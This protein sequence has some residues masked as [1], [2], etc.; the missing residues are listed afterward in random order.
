MRCCRSMKQGH[1]RQLGA[2]RAPT[3]QQPM[4]RY[5]VRTGVAVV[6]RALCHYLGELGLSYTDLGFI[7]HILSYRWTTA[8]PFPAQR[9]LAQQAGVGRTGIQRRVYAL[10]S[11]G[12]LEIAERYTQDDGR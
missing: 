11:L 10:Q 1:R 5:S 2:A 4:R 7:T 3:R 6:P 8:Y 12:Y 9:K